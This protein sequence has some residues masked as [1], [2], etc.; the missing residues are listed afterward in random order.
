MPIYYNPDATD[1]EISECIGDY[2]GCEICCNQGRCFSMLR[3]KLEA[4]LRE[5]GQMEMSYLDLLVK[6]KSD[7]ESDCIP[8]DEKKTVLTLIAQ[9]EEKLWKYSY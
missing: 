4:T 9:L 2:Y 5:E 7:V 1:E 8:V 6:L 3:D